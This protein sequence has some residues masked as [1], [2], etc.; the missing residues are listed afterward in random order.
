MFCM[1][2]TGGGVKCIYYSVSPFFF[3]S[4]FNSKCC[5]LYW[6]QQPM[7]RC[8][9]VSNDATL[10]EVTMIIIIMH[11][12]SCNIKKKKKTSTVKLQQISISFIFSAVA[13]VLLL[14][15]RSHEGSLWSAKR[16]VM[17]SRNRW[18]AGFKLFCCWALLPRYIAHRG[19]IAMATFQ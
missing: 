6:W 18:P 12:M 13:I 1:C 8:R 3:L 19:D 2:C 9:C 16:I 17:Q 11:I 15:H 14:H 5:H 4:T 10:E 7:L